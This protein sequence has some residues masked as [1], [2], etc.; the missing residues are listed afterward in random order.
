MDDLTIVAD[1]LITWFNNENIQ[2]SNNLNDIINY[3]IND[4]TEA[5]KNSLKHNIRSSLALFRK[6]GLSDTSKEKLKTALNEF[7]YNMEILINR[8]IDRIINTFNKYKKTNQRYT[9]QRVKLYITIPLNENTKNRL[10]KLAAQIEKKLG[11]DEYTEKENEDCIECL[12][13]FRWLFDAPLD[14]DLYRVLNDY[15]SK[16]MTTTLCPKYDIIDLKLH[17][18]TLDDIGHMLEIMVEWLIK[19][20][21]CHIKCENNCLSQEFLKCIDRDIIT[22]NNYYRIRNNKEK[23]IDKLF[24]NETSLQQF[25]T[26][27]KTKPIKE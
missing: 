8:V 21:L 18:L 6:E 26:D 17:V 9:L 3:L 1:E 11:V 2:Y 4:A 16:N 25:I 23:N 12:K 13:Y 10:K 22:A 14:I 27:H 19:C 20:D 24:Y 5:N 7:K 15:K